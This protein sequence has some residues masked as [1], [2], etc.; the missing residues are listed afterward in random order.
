LL[1]VVGAEILLSGSEDKNLTALL[2]L[3]AFEK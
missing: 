2:A 1:V 3:R